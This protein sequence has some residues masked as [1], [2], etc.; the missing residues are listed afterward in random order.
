MTTAATVTTLQHDLNKSGLVNPVPNKD[1]QIHH[2]STFLEA[3][4]ES[5]IGLGMTVLSPVVL[6]VI[7]VLSLS[8]KIADLSHFFA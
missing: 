1:L 3:L 4:V 8:K 7:F 2:T 6:L 5:G